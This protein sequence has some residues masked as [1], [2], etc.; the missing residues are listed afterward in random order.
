MHVERV[1]V[2]EL[3]DHVLRAGKRLFE[4][5]RGAQGINAA[6]VRG[7][8]H[9]CPTPVLTELAVLV[10]LVACHNIA[11]KYYAIDEDDHV[12][13]YWKER[14]LEVVFKCLKKTSKKTQRWWHRYFSTVDLCGPECAVMNAFGWDVRSFMKPRQERVRR[15]KLSVTLRISCGIFSGFTHDMDVCGDT[16]RAALTG[17]LTKALSGHLSQ[18]GM[19]NLAQESLDMTWDMWPP[20]VAAILQSGGDS[21]VFSPSAFHAARKGALV[22]GPRTA[23]P[24]P[25][26]KPPAFP[27]APWARA[28]AQ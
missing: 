7:I 20:T 25:H 3:V 17:A 1:A 12:Y 13:D 21:V 27:E 22:P 11:N 5:T 6:I 8:V 14:C 4:A 10:R 16:T 15:R 2:T 23:R 26:G 9:Q 19:T 18:S 24:Q 28:V